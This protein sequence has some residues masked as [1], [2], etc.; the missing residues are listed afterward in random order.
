LCDHI[1]K[2]AQAFSS[3]YTEC[4]ILVDDTPHDVRA[5]RLSLAQLTLR[6]L[7]MGLNILGIDAPERM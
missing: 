3:F 4:P 2:V 1:Y 6:Q 5:S 7:E